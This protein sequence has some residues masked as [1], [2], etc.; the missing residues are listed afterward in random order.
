MYYQYAIFAILSPRPVYY[1]QH[2][3]LRNNLYF[4]HIVGHQVSNTFKIL[5]VSN[6][7][8]FSRDNNI[9]NL[10]CFL[11]VPFPLCLIIET[12]HAYLLITK[13]KKRIS[14]NSGP[15]II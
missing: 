10:R 13:M 7:P 15:V 1:P 14:A 6:V 4:S 3:F 11:C 9:I 2:L 5:V 8:S 12:T